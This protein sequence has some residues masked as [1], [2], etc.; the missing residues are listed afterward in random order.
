MRKQDLVTVFGDK[1][2]SQSLVKSTDPKYAST[3]V[4]SSAT[5]SSSSAAKGA[6]TVPAEG[7][8]PPAKAAAPKK[9]KKEKKKLI[10][11]APPSGTRDFF[12]DE[13]K[14]EQW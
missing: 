6:M 8:A 5:S 10:D 14:Q 11:L 13:M 4:S 2:L 12:P 1:S 9:D 7:G 3:L